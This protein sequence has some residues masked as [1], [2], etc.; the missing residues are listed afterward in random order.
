M[1]RFFNSAFVTRPI[2]LLLLFVAINLPLVLMGVPV[3]LPELKF[4]VLG[5]RL[6][7][8]AAMYRD[9]F[10]TTGPLAALVF[11]VI[12]LLDGRSLLMYR[13]VAAF[14]LLF[15]ALNMNFIFNRQHVFAQKTY[16]PAL[17]YMLGGS[18]FFEFD[19]LS[20]VLLGQTFLVFSI[21]Y[22][23]IVSKE[24]S[25]NPKL[26][27]AGFFIGLAALSYLPFS[28]FLIVAY[29][30]VASF[31]SNTFRSF[32]LLL[33]GFFFP[34]AV[35]ATYYLYNGALDNFQEFYLSAEGLFSFHLQLPLA[36]LLKLLALPLLLI[37]A[38]IFMAASANQGLVFQQK[39]QQLMF[40]WFWVAVVMLLASPQISV[41][42]FIYFLPV[43]AYYS[44][45]L[46]RPGARWWIPEV[47]FL[48]LLTLLLAVRYAVPLH[49]EQYLN[50]NTSALHLKTDEK[51][52]KIV[53]GQLL[54]LGPDF[55]YYAYNYAASPYL[56]WSLAQKD[57]RNL[58]TY[59]AVLAIQENIVQNPPEFIV[60]EVHLMPELAYK[61]PLVFGRYEPAGAVGLYRLKR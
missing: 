26:F 55:Q 60:D 29:F 58:D 8:G 38:G 7:E 3:T 32:L 51:Y 37:L 49:I 48:V 28:F 6:Q 21:R 22:L 42:N 14:L 54:V 31:A 5:E 17:L 11:W 45:Y 44:F 35:V 12:D 56:N 23:V 52:K 9:V 24:G 15:Q 57:F 30:A 1:I 18:F 13:L 16:L 10:D 36:D 59:E 43:L 4:M 50:I 19:T 33:T 47:I 27:K 41:L 25:N 46:F 61:L 20:P 53:N 39:M 40:V 2:F 34:F